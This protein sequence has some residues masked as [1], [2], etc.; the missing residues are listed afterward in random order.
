MEGAESEGDGADGADQGA[1]QAAEDWC[2]E[3]DKLWPPSD[4]DVEDEEVS[5]KKRKL[6][7]A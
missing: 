5:V 6:A 1:D 7:H 4:T 3:L 2:D